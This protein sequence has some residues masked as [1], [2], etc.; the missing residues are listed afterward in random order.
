MDEDWTNLGSPK[1]RKSR[2]MY[3]LW[4]LLILVVLTAIAFWL[5]YKAGQARLKQLEDSSDYQQAIYFV[6]FNKNN[7]FYS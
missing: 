4:G 5:L 6:N 1:P 2:P 3:G 7:T